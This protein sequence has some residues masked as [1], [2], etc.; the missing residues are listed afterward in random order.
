MFSGSNDDL[1]SVSLSSRN[2]LDSSSNLLKNDTSWK[3][4]G[5]TYSFSE[6]GECGSVVFET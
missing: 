5:E 6:N 3:L 4:G 1:A 2:E